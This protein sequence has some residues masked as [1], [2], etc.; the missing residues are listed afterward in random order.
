MPRQRYKVRDREQE[1]NK[2]KHIERGT[3][4]KSEFERGQ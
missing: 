2:K 4:R 3:V 1:R